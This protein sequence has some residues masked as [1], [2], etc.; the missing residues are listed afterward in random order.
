[1]SYLLPC[2]ACG[3]KLSVVT[4]QAGQ[5]VRCDC[6]A[7]LEVPTIRG[8]RELEQVSDD[9][10]SFSRW[11]TRHGVAFLGLLI[12]AGALAF[13]LYLHLRAPVFDPTGYESQVQAA[14]P[15]QS[16]EH[17]TGNLR[18]GPRMRI[19][20]SEHDAIVRRAEKDKYVER[21]E[22]VGYGVA[23]LGLV[24]ALAGWFGL[25]PRAVQ[26]SRS[27]VQGRV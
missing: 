12:L 4:G 3:N 19:R 6:G 27:K 5:L 17:W 26:A 23:A 15:E 8:L 18:Y 2:P 1:M 11:T 13:S 16:W 21:W 24:I 14:S 10:V 25:R 22:W 7:D 9:A 20:Q